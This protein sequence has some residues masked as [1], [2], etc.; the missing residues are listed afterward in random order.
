LA[1]NLH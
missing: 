1:G